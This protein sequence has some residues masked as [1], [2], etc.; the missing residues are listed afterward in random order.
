MTF[1]SQ[2]LESWSLG[3]Y[4]VAFAVASSGISVRS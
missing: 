4:E 3:V 1:V 2:P